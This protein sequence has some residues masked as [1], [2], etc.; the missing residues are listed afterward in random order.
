MLL[1]SGSTI[2]AVGQDTR[3]MDNLPSQIFAVGHDLQ[4]YYL[5]PIKEKFNEPDDYDESF[6]GPK[7][8]YL[9]NRAKAETGN[10]GYLFSG[11]KGMGKTLL[12]EMIANRLELP[13]VIIETNSLVDN[14]NL[15]QFLF[16]LDSS[17]VI[18]IDEF[19]KKLSQTA[20]EQLLS[21]F[22][23][24]YNS[25]KKKVFLLSCNQEN[26]NDAFLGRLGRILYKVPFKAIKD[27]GVCVKFMQKHTSLNDEQIDK[28]VDLL[29]TKQQVTIDIL[30]KIAK[31]VRLNSFDTFISIGWPMLNLE[32]VE[33]E[34][35]CETYD[36][37]A[38]ESESTAYNRPLSD[39]VKVMSMSFGQRDA[40]LVNL[41]KKRAEDGKYA[42]TTEETIT[43]NY[44]ENTTG[45]YFTAKKSADELK[46]GDTLDNCYYTICAIER[47][48]TN[49]FLKVH[50]THDPT[51]GYYC[52]ICRQH[53]YGAF[54]FIANS[55]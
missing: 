22:D 40:F 19:E 41:H 7:L 45:R 1:K 29:S 37:D 30:H 2:R 3:T 38:D 23:G 35:Y 46:V 47:T 18:I 50:Q 9:V 53:G 20:Q 39:F 15:F 6:F 14:N 24:I 36:F 31:E 28:L 8:D 26:I 11:V 55:F 16:A 42:S 17:M 33:F 4:G 32:D 5:E 44:I 12:M 13:V 54:N 48:K 49:I 27:K 52:K 34:Y 21:F 43:E 51:E 25:N 10:V